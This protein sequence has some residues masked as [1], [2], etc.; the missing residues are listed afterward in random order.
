MTQFLF[1]YLEE[2]DVLGDADHL[3]IVR[4]HL[5][6]EIDKLTGVKATA[7]SIEVLHELF[8]HYFGVE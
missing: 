5:G 8:D 6:G 2:V 3:F 7:V 1:G 4:H